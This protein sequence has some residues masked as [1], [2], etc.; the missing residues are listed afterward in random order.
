MCGLVCGMPCALVVIVVAGGL[1]TNDV[2]VTWTTTGA[3]DYAVFRTLNPAA[4]GSAV[5]TVA[6]PPATFIN[7]C[8]DGLLVFYDVE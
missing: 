1:P 3:A 8:G 7:E 4:I 5:Q 2:A 6:A